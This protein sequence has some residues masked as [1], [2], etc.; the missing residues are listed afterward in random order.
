M[1]KTPDDLAHCSYPAP[2]DAPSLESLTS[3][4]TLRPEAGD[5]ASESSPSKGTGVSLA[6]E[7]PMRAPPLPRSTLARFRKP[8]RSEWPHRGRAKEPP[9]AAVVM[10]AP[11]DGVAA[12]GVARGAADVMDLR[13]DDFDSEAEESAAQASRSPWENPLS[14]LGHWSG[15]PTPPRKHRRRAWA[16]P[17]ASDL[18]CAAVV[19]EVGLPAFTCAAPTLGAPALMATR[20]AALL[21]PTPGAASTAE[22]GEEEEDEAGLDAEDESEAPPMQ[23]HES[24]E[25]E[26]ESDAE[27]DQAPQAKRRSGYWRVYRAQRRK[28]GLPVPRGGR[29]TFAVRR[30]SRQASPA[31]RPSPRNGVIEPTASLSRLLAAEPSISAAHPGGPLST[32]AASPVR[33]SPLA[34]A[35]P[36]PVRDTRV[37]SPLAGPPESRA[38]VPPAAPPPAA[39][40]PSVASWSMGTSP[41]PSAAAPVGAS[42]STAAPPS[43]AAQ[44][45]RS[46]ERKV[47]ALTFNTREGTCGICCEDIAASQGVRLACSHGWYCTQC[48]RRHTEAR[49]SSGSCSVPCPECN[50]VIAEHDLRKVL[51]LELVDR[52]AERSLELAVNS[53]EDLWACPTPDCPFRVSMEVDDIP[54]LHCPKCRKTSCLK[55][56]MQPWHKGLTC[57]EAALKRSTGSKRKRCEADE[58]MKRWCEETGT[59]QCPTCRM[60]ISKQKL[61]NQLTQYSECHKMCCRNCMTRFCFKCLAVLSETYTCGCS[62]DDHG[63]VD[64]RSGKRVEHLLPAAR[65]RPGRA[66]KQQARGV[67]RGRQSGGQGRG[68][69]AARAVAKAC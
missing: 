67:G 38:S 32:A 56:G 41:M 12:L 63:F 10:E 22:V 43:T 14:F 18:P 37:A 35:S 5:S 8:R 16:F 17:A 15:P 66:A 60:A 55:C 51:P 27:E 53:L 46:P 52:L 9:P 65:K 2:V 4:A 29:T 26:S 40:S 21:A 30:K 6:A 64:P 50:T 61:D 54:R 25:L 39:A 42:P 68:R 62:I 45:S 20:P 11:P 48:V 23:S 28:V 49:L 31:I 13:S 59:R 44:S 1:R 57:E 58:A 33:A 24:T 19:P 47:T 69:A 34:G 36:P 7:S 3:G